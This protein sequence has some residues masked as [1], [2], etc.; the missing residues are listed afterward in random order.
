MQHKPCHRR[1][2]CL[3]SPSARDRRSDPFLLRSLSQ[4]YSALFTP[5]F[6]SSRPSDREA[7]QNGHQARAR[8]SDHSCPRRA[9][10]IRAL[11]QAAVRSRSGWF[12]EG[13]DRRPTPTRDQPV[14]FA[15]FHSCWPNRTA[16]RSLGLAVAARRL[17]A[18][19]GERRRLAAPGRRLRPHARAG[20]AEV[21]S[22]RAGRRRT[23]PSR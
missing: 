2:F 3:A 5:P 4:N 18:P 21:G 8:A 16:S 15:W 10:R 6:L 20:W 17:G 9:V 19:A 22:S 23:R 7:V 11:W 1:C 13:Y 12:V 14:D